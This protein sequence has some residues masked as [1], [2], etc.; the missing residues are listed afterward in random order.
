MAIVLGAKQF[1]LIIIAVQLV[2]FGLTVTLMPRER[3]IVYKNAYEHNE[4]C[5]VNIERT[6]INLDELREAVQQ[7]DWDYD[8]FVENKKAFIARTKDMDTG[9]RYIMESAMYVS[10]PECLPSH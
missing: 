4:L 7:L 3:H 8:L 5:R 2:V 10:S 9:I 1:G 6:L